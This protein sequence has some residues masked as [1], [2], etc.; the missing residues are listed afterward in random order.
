MGWNMRD[1]SI[2]E[3]IEIINNCD[4]SFNP[5]TRHFDVRNV[6]RI[7]DFGL[8]FKTFLYE[9]PLRP[10]FSDFQTL[11]NVMSFSLIPRSK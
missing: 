8:I 6:Q 4:E 11:L 3:A 2:E 5:D 1:Y 10:I 9:Y 7:G